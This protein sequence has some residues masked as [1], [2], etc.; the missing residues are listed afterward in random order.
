MSS[1]PRPHRARC[2][3]RTTRTPHM[4]RNICQRVPAP[5][6]RRRRRAQ[7]LGTW[8]K[9]A[10]RTPA[11]CRRGLASE[12]PWRARVVNRACGQPESSIH[13]SPC[14]ST[15]PRPRA[16]ST[17]FH[18]YARAM[19]R[20][21]GPLIP[22]LPPA[23]LLLTPRAKLASRLF[24]LCFLFKILIYIRKIIRYF[25]AL[26]SDKINHNKNTHSINFFYHY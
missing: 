19:E 17:S 12:L 5:V 26:F 9:R 25:F 22:L 8:K 14:S 13:V 10:A 2:S 18:T 4:Q 3:S 6:A 7:L 23:L 24:N 16:V 11:V 1:C 21:R 20:C 15:P